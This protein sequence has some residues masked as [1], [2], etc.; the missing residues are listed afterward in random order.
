MNLT[1]KVGLTSF[2]FRTAVI[3]TSG[4]ALIDMSRATGYC[5]IASPRPRGKPSPVDRELHGRESP[6]CG[7]FLQVPVYGLETAVIGRIAVP[8]TTTISNN[9]K[10]ESSG[11]QILEA[12]SQSQPYR[13]Y[14][15]A[16]TQGTG[17][18]LAR[19]SQTGD[20]AS[21]KSKQKTTQLL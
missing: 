20:D 21:N 2:I 11:N 7:A 13:D 19:S 9:M 14:E 6:H 8:T 15:L 10:A 5:L 16:F 4:T 12:L 1:A 17:L 3:E 18:P